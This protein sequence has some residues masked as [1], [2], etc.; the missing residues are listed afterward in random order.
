MT[1]K[2]NGEITALKSTY[3]FIVDNEGHYRCFHE[4]YLLRR[5]FDD[6]QIGDRVEFTPFVGPRGRRAEDVEVVDDRRRTQ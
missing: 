3:G 2:F 1:R 5:S 4:K 6:L